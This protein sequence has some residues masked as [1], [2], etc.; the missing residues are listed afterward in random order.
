MMNNLEIKDDKVENIVK[1]ALDP[2][3]PVD[4]RDR[5]TSVRTL[6]EKIEELKEALQNLDNENK[7]LDDRKIV[8][9]HK[10]DN[11]DDEK[12]ETD[13][14]IRRLEEQIES[15]KIDR[16]DKSNPI[17]RRLLSAKEERTALDDLTVGF[18]KEEKDIDETKEKNASLKDDIEDQ[19]QRIEEAKE[20]INTKIASDKMQQTA[21]KA[22]EKAERNTSHERDPFLVILES[23][24]KRYQNIQERDRMLAEAAKNE[25]ANQEKLESRYAVN[26][27]EAGDTIKENQREE[28]KEKDDV[29]VSVVITDKLSDTTQ[30]KILTPEEFVAFSKE[31]ETGKIKERLESEKDFADKD[32]TVTVI[33]SSHESKKALLGKLEPIM[34]SAVDNPQDIGQYANTKTRRNSLI[35]AILDNAK[36]SQKL[37]GKTEAE[38]VITPT[39]LAKASQPEMNIHEI[40][41]SEG[42]QM[43]SKD[44]IPWSHLKN[45]NMTRSMLTP[46]D[47]EALRHKGT[48][49][50]ITIQGK[51][52]KGDIVKKR[53]KL[54]LAN[55]IGGTL[56]F[57]MLP[58]LPKSNVDKRQKIG[59][60][61]FTDKDK[62]MLKKFGQLN[63]LVPFT[64]QDGNTK[65]LMV[66][67]D[68]QTNTLFTCDPAKVTLPKFITEQCTKEELRKIRNGQPVHVENLKDNAGQKFNGWVV[69]SPHTNG[70]LL[71]LSHIDKDFVPQVRNNNYG[72]R[73]ELLKED[74]DAKVMTKQTRS[75]DGEDQ[76]I[77]NSHRRA[78]ELLHL[79]HIDK[80]FDPQVRNN[81]DGEDQKIQT[82]HR[83]ALDFSTDNNGDTTERS[84]TIKTTK[85]M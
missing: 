32:K 59:D 65:M 58:V 85:R 49:D 5:E 4:E 20:K 35:S 12:A 80:D 48:T 22:K 27:T 74:K 60:I 62:E 50:L 23:F 46:E 70:K 51:N 73:T 41:N 17:V 25:S 69:M 40:V 9:E 64:S 72:E 18:Q 66:G 1:R 53:F 36:E 84:R 45:F 3:V 16:E 82:S 75:N 61:D 71:H 34:K 54:S 21:D 33:V 38:Q 52:W 29:C 76:K 14:K 47:I 7:T 31:E 43:L 77:Q 13:K 78:L 44:D 24:F 63:H 6:N 56:T 19:I 67:L 28:K 42:S 79:S 26:V 10:I 55:D 81:N 15:E 57:R 68:K 2:Q 8:L 39:S 83:K 37:G 30:V 11:N